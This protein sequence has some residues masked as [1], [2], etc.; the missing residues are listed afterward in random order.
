MVMGSASRAY[1]LDGD[2]TVRSLTPSGANSVVGRI[3]GS[4]SAEAGFAVSPDDKRIAVSVIDY[5]RT[6]PTTRLYVED[7][8]GANHT[9]LLSSSTAYVWPIAW[10]AGTLV[11]AV[12]PSSAQ[13]VVA[14]PYDAI[15]G[16]HLVDAAN[17]NRLAT[18]CPP[19]LSPTGAIAGNGTVCQKPDG[20]VWLAGWDGTLQALPADCYQLSPGGRSA[21]CRGATTNA[22]P[23]API[24]I[25][26][27]GGARVVTPARGSGPLGWVDDEHL[28]YAAGAGYDADVRLLDVPSGVIT[29]IGDHL[30]VVGRVG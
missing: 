18:I 9:E 11:L 3:P 21:A 22:A 28:I 17:G 27:I 24:S 16:Y 5:S 26:R 30:A 19:P 29:P 15:S 10:R 13:Y 12:G 6:P 4:S 8:T 20:S 2:S 1:F 14:K 7:L 23:I 25:F